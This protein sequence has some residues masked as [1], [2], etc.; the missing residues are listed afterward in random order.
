VLS[1]LF[2]EAAVICYMVTVGP[3]GAAYPLPDVPPS[4]PAAPSIWLLWRAGV[5]R[6]DADGLFHGSRR[7][8]EDEAIVL[9]ARLAAAVASELVLRD[10]HS[11]DAFLGR[12]AP[13]P[14][15]DVSPYASTHWAFHSWVYLWH[16]SPAG[17]DLL[18][19]WGRP[20]PTR[21]EA[22]M[23]A[24]TVLRE[25]RRSARAKAAL[26]L[27]KQT[28]DVA[29]QQDTRPL[30]WMPGPHEEESEGVPGPG[31]MVP[32]NGREA[33]PSGPLGPTP[34]PGPAAQAP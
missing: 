4:H 11:I 18:G 19:G 29:P 3:S 17:T 7:L 12:W 13:P 32:R 34:Q 20:L 15:P 5:V 30:D 22:A 8:T 21:Y 1:A 14:Q 9:S 27:R 24:A 25:A 6:G 26:I 16:A 33:M 10:G 23:A 28:D 2:R 31:P